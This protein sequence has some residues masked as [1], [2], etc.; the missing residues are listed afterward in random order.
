MRDVDGA[1]IDWTAYGE[2]LRLCLAADALTRARVAQTA[3]TTRQAAWRCRARLVPQM[4]PRR[5]LLRGRG[6]ERLIGPCLT[7]PGRTRPGRAASLD[8]GRVSY[9]QRR[10]SSVTERTLRDADEMSLCVCLAR[11]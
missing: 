4:V 7:A 10:Q 3:G 2:A 6:A 9:L 5:R 1:M 11:V 8:G